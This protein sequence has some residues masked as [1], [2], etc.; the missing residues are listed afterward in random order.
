MR[1]RKKSGPVGWQLEELQQFS[2][3][4]WL[5]E[6][7]VQQ[8]TEFIILGAKHDSSSGHL[9]VFKFA[10]IRVS[11]LQSCPKLHMI[12]R[13]DKETIV[14]LTLNGRHGGEQ[15]L[16]IVNPENAD[17]RRFFLL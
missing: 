4:A 9:L 17:Q 7:P 16:A 6:H 15:H 8:N 11:P 10:Q 2:F 1:I 3:P 12:E 5:H 13:A 14:K